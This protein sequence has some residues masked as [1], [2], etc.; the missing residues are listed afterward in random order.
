[1]IP[2]DVLGELSGGLGS[3]SSLSDMGIEA[4]G[5]LGERINEQLG[6]AMEDA[7]KAIDEAKKTGEDLQKQAED[8]QNQVNDAADKV[9]G[10]FG[11]G[12]KDEP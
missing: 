9:K 5:V 7:Q 1:M 6:G 2:A 12:K 10:I 8:I 3:L 4:V 11:G